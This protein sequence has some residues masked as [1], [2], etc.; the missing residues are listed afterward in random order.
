MDFLNKYHSDIIAI[1]ALV[2]SISQIIFNAWHNRF[3]ISM[4]VENVDQE[5][6]KKRKEC[7]ICFSF[8]NNSTSPINILRLKLQDKNGVW[9]PCRLRKAPVFMHHWPKYPETDIPSSERTFS[10]DFPVHI[11]SRGATNIIATFERSKDSQDFGAGEILKVKVE[12][13]KGFV[14]LYDYCKI[15]S[16]NDMAKFY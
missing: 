13:D 6:L 12:T 14:V 1:F 2:V 8:V 7:I 4:L 16:I 11:G 5:D 3:N 15:C 9:I 10:T